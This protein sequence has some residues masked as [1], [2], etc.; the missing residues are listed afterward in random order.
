MEEGKTEMTVEEK[1]KTLEQLEKI[2]FS[3]RD[4]LT[5]GKQK[6]FCDIRTALSRQESNQKS[7]E[8][9]SDLWVRLSDHQQEIDDCKAS[10]Q[11]LK[12]TIPK[13]DAKISF[14][15]TRLKAC[16]RLI[17][18]MQRERGE[19]KQK[20][21]QFEEFLVAWTE[22]DM[23]GYTFGRTH[24]DDYGKKNAHYYPSQDLDLVLDFFFGLR[25]LL[26]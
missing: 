21:Q 18:E 15:E 2:A 14:L 12:D 25:E 1:A 9:H 19:Q 6:P 23:N 20:L 16:N 17:D 10:W 5:W 13:F 4:E 3:L 26:K 8:Y 7:A 24:M 22:N 11:N